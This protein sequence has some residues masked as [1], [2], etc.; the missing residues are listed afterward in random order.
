MMSPIWAS[1]LR[2]RASA[3]RNLGL[4]VLDQ[5]HD[6]QIARDMGLAGLGIDID[7]DVVLGAVMGLGGALHRLFHRGQHHLLVDGFVARDGVGDL[8]KFEPVGGNC[9]LA[10]LVS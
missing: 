4:V 5:L 2:R 9:A 3:R 6:M 8:Q 7:L 1:G 10:I